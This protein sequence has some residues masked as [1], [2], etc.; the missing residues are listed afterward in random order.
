MSEQ[1]I[2][3][4]IMD[5]TTWEEPDRVKNDRQE[6]EYTKKMKGDFGFFGIGTFLYSC[7]YAFCMFHNP[8]G[9]TF[10]FF[11]AGSLLFFCFCLSKLGISLRKGSAFYM[12]SIMLLAVSTFCTDDGRIIGMNKLGIL[13]LL[14]SFLL[15]Q[16][17]DTSQWGLGN[18]VSSIVMT[19]FCS[20]GCLNRPFQDGNH[21]RK[22]VIR[23]KG[24]KLLYVIAGLLVAI[25]IVTFV[26]LLLIF[27][28]AVFREMG[29]AL[30][31]SI[32]FDT[33][34]EIAAMIVCCFLAVYCI[35]S[36]LCEKKL[37]EEAGD[38]RHGEPLLA[39]TVTGMLTLL[40]L[41]FSVIQVLGLFLGKLQL[42]AGYTYA[43]YAR[44][45]FFQLLAVSVLNL[46][47][48][49]TVL[50]FFRE[51]RVLKGILVVMSLCTFIMIASSAMRMVLYISSYNLTF[52]RIFVLWS[53]AVLT[54]LFLGVVL[55]IFKKKFPLFRYSCVIVTCCYLVLSFGHPDY[56]IARV[57]VE[58]EKRDDSYLSGL[59]ADAA[60]VLLPWLREQAQK[61]GWEESPAG[62]VSIDGE[63]GGY[64]SRR[65]GS[66][67]EYV[68]R[69]LRKTE[70]YDSILQ[71]NVSRYMA[72]KQLKAA[73]EWEEMAAVLDK[74]GEQP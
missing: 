7:L 69:M 38:R 31:D 21:F 9:V 20:L 11:A 56:W 52:L 14:I 73:G 49:L 8:S 15:N 3:G 1:A 24:Q 55:S 60:P 34:F 72:A 70:N 51:S 45:G 16:I 37:K 5:N 59:S 67:Q 68:R 32:N 42:P 18:Y 40:Y 25:P 39:I 4:K 48:V 41:V 53:L 64:D 23:G 58:S 50:A 63:A 44:E 6:T 28:D 74:G 30:L 54:F 2:S 36:F 33:I 66:T 46:I 57:N 29:E 13:L 61:E 12:V 19:L 35:L 71:F 65:D 62:D 47:I 22:T 10:P 17:Y 43:R 27:A 26:F